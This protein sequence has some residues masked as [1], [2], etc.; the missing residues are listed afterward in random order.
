MSEMLASKWGFTGTSCQLMSVKL[1]DD[2]L[3]CHGNKIWGK[4]GY[5]SAGTRHF[6]DPCA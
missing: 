3:Y 2:Q 5:N 6:R 1:C 4:I